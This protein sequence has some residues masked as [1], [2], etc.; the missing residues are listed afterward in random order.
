M[1]DSANPWMF[2]SSL[3]GFVRPEAIA[4]WASLVGTF[5]LGWLLAR[6]TRSPKGARSEKDGQPV[7]PS[8]RMA[9]AAF[10]RE[11]DRVRRY[12]HALA[13]LVLMLEDVHTP[14]GSLGRVSANGTAPEG[15]ESMLLAARQV[16]FWNVGYVLHD[17]LRESDVVGCDVAN[18]RY[19]V[20]LPEAGEELASLAAERIEQ[21]IFQTI[22]VPLR[23]GIA[24]FRTDGL[25]I[26]DLVSVATASCDRTAA[27]RTVPRR[28]ARGRPQSSRLSDPR[29][30]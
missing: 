11:L 3:S 9:R 10:A 26:E 12:D 1:M 19:V 4:I 27:S 14:D 8:L 20:L 24:L 6:R 16:A 13:V 28:F 22:G 25:T 7:I 21:R 18:G 23:R 2:P 15:H 17:L 5:T 30:S 29:S